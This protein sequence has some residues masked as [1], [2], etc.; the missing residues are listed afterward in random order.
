MGAEQT[1][2]LDDLLMGNVGEGSE[3]TSEQLI[4]RIAAAQARLAAVKKDEKKS[5]VHD[6]QLAQIIKYLPL[7]FN[8]F[9]NFLNILKSGLS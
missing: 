1:G 6:R 2:G 7:F 9:F 3:E 4:A 5:S 8:V